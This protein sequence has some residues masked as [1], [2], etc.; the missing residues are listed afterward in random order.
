ML[1]RS[2]TILTLVGVI[3][4]SGLG[5]VVLHLCSME[6]AVRSTCCCHEATHDAPPI[7]LKALDDCCSAPFVQDRQPRVAETSALSVKLSP[8]AAPAASIL[9]VGHAALSDDCIVLPA[10][11]PP[12]RYG[13]PLFLQ[14]CSFL[15]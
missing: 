8:I 4:G 12:P 2:F 5:G 1:H 11:G 9:A 13:P 15:N 10:R 7:Q 3:A 6:H 14:Y